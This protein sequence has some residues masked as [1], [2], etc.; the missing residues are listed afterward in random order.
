MI[1]Q[2]LLTHCTYGT[3]ALERKKGEM[4]RHPMGYSVRSASLEGER[5]REFFRRLE[6]YVY[7]YL[8]V[9]M[10]AE[11]RE[12]LS[13]ETAP[14]RYVYLPTM[15][16]GPALLN[17][18]YRQKDTAGRV[19]SYFAHTLVGEKK[20]GED[21]EKILAL[22]KAPGWIEE[23]GDFLDYELPT[24]S[25][26]EEMLEGREPAIQERVF[27][28]YLQ[29]EKDGDFWD[30]RNVIPPRWRKMSVECRREI[31]RK[32]LRGFLKIRDDREG[33]LL[34]LAEPS[35][36]ALFFYGIS[37]FVPRG[38]T[39]GL[40]FSTYEPQPQRGMTKLSATLLE[41]P[42]KNDLE[43]ER[44]HGQAWV[45]NTWN[46]RCSEEGDSR[47]GY[48]AQI[49]NEFYTHGLPGV[50]R[51]CK[52][53][54][55][56]GVRTAVDLTAMTK[57]GDVFSRIFSPQEEN[58]LPYTLGELSIAKSPMAVAYLKRRTA[59]QVGTLSR[60]EVMELVG[61]PGQSLILE[62]LGT[63]SEKPE[64]QSGV[65]LLLAN[66][67][68]NQ[69]SSWLRYA[70]VSE[71]LVSKVLERWIR[72]NGGLP[73]DCVFLWQDAMTAIFSEVGKEGTLRKFVMPLV[74]VRLPE[75]ILE[76]FYGQCAAEHGK[77]FLVALAAGVSFWMDRKGATH[78][79]V[80]QAR[81]RLDHLVEQVPA[82]VFLELYRTYGCWF[83]QNYPGDSQRLGKKAAAWGDDILDR[84][85]E[86]PA[87]LNILNDVQDILPD[88]ARRH[89]QNWKRLQETAMQVVILQGNAE[90]KVGKASALEAA[91]LAFAKNGRTVFE[92]I[93]WTGRLYGVL[94]EVF[95]GWTGEPFL[96][97]GWMVHEQLNPK[98][99][100]YLR[101]GNWPA[102]KVGGWFASK[103]ARQNAIVIGLG[104]L[105]VGLVATLLFFL[106]LGGE[107]A[108]KET[109]PPT[110]EVTAEKEREEKSTPPK[111]KKRVKQEEIPLPP[112]EKEDVL[113]EEPKPEAE[114]VE[115]ETEENPDAWP[116]ETTSQQ[117]LA[118]WDALLKEVPPNASL[119]MTLRESG[120][121]MVST[122]DVQT[123]G[124]WHS[125][126]MRGV[127]LEGGYL[128]FEETAFPFG[129]NLPEGILPP[130][131]RGKKEAKSEGALPR[132][133]VL[134]EDELQE[135]SSGRVSMKEPMVLDIP[136]R[137]YTLP[138]LAEALE[139]AAVMVEMR[140]DE[141][142]LY[143]LHVETIR[144]QVSPREI[145]KQEEHRQKI[146]RLESENRVLRS[147]IRA[148]E[149]AMKGGAEGAKKRDLMLRLAKQMEMEIELPGEK[150]IRNQFATQRL[151]E[152]AVEGYRRAMESQEKVYQNLLLRANEMVAAREKDLES[153]RFQVIP[154]DGELSPR[155]EAIW[156][157]FQ[158]GC[159]KLVVVVGSESGLGMAVGES[160]FA[161]EELEEEKPL[162]KKKERVSVE[163]THLPAER[164][165]SGPFREE[166]KETFA[167]TEEEDPFAAEDVPETEGKEVPVERGNLPEG[168]DVLNVLWH[169][170]DTENA[171]RRQ[172][173]H[174]KA[175]LQVAVSPE[176]RKHWGILEQYYAEAEVL[177]H[178]GE[179][180]RGM[181]VENVITRKISP[182]GKIVPTTKKVALLIR[183]SKKLPD[184]TTGPVVFQTNWFTIEPIQDGKRYRVEGKLEPES[185]QVLEERL[186][187]E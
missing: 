13:A 12:F 100:A 102:G 84:P 86:I 38:V 31:F 183:F 101:T 176:E 44:Y 59:E 71:E 20:G 88:V 128:L 105:G 180:E 152:T 96:P 35:M 79:L 163:E 130:V 111:P 168:V 63:G 36:A 83:F 42:E 162:R 17:V 99:E 172:L 144:K 108:K 119:A 89:V 134:S 48:V 32:I 164:S 120:R 6:R 51:F 147:S 129:E 133:H 43:E 90:R 70:P 127:R 158:A 126:Q 138:E 11:E 151:Y 9:D 50:S 125:R 160:P 106:L 67:Q 143:Y 184:G 75:E 182:V 123:L 150:P 68:E 66:L 91:C 131:R 10:T 165:P 166:A 161:K 187:R 40:S 18:V 55:S 72:R 4:A 179:E 181:R 93:P 145:A 122:V 16:G 95:R 109:E 153:L 171:T 30:P 62:L 56:V 22:W 173:G 169:L 140:P 74:L 15:D 27:L 94:K 113:P 132:K 114:P 149:A 33:N 80:T 178:N 177:Q 139:M 23:D 104:G 146:E 154:E 103:R 98:V 185:I 24:L 47:D 57:V 69:L 121:G 118:A 52:N 82:A 137:R 136:G 26:L 60:E 142:G 41:H 97:P 174:E 156:E 58:P 186:D 159:R 124:K 155:E 78:E 87:L 34:L 167:E 116:F 8:P 25:R 135:H 92:G 37:L 148:C 85:A 5:L 77:E 115:E 39:R 45:L 141:E 61:T 28:S 112:P 175:L 110:V 81:Q 19:G 14:C 29:T 53:L 54:E 64:V 7:Y 21:W 157:R 2:L 117:T 65:Q 76:D 1:Q 46:G 49:W 3:S 170:D 107:G 73:D